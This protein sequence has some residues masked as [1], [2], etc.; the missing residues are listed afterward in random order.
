VRRISADGRKLFGSK[1][2]VDIVQRTAAYQRQRARGLFEQPVEGLG[3]TRR[4]PHLARRR[5]QIKQR[6]VDVE[7]HRAFVQPPRQFARRRN[8]IRQRLAG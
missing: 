4:H 3:K 6:A 7:Q 1:N 5:R 2:Q 8:Q